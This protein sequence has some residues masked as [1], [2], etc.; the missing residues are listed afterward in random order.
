MSPRCRYGPRD[1]EPF[2]MLTLAEGRLIQVPSGAA[3]GAAQMPMPS[4]ITSRSGLS[5][6][7]N[8]QKR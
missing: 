5:L 2:V 7:S 3:T 6:N 4:V 1:G 8:T